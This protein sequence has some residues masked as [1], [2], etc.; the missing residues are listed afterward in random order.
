MMKTFLRWLLRCLFRF[1][2]YNESVLNTPG[3]VLLV[4]NHVSW[5]DWLFLVACLDGD[6][7]FVV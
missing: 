5:I 1:R 6:W 2:G 7:K 3:P 4:P